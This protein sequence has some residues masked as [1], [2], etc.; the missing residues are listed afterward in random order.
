MMSATE[1]LR[2]TLSSRSLAELAL[3]GGLARLFEA[4]PP[5]VTAAK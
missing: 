2:A 5:E 3:A 1:S 4:G